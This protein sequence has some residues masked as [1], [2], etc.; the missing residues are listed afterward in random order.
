VILERKIAADY[1]MGEHT[2]NEQL[3]KRLYSNILLIQ[4]Q[5]FAVDYMI[6]EHK[7][8]E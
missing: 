5:K 1:Q 8:N 2:R 4:E 6:D 7:T 3:I